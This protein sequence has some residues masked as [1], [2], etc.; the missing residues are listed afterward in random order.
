[1]LLGEPGWISVPE[2]VRVSGA[3][4]EACRADVRLMVEILD[5]VP[6]EPLPSGLEPGQRWVLP[7]RQIEPREQTAYELAA[8][9]FD[10]DAVAAEI[11]TTSAA[12]A[13]VAAKRHAVRVRLPWPPAKG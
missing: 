8:E 5:L 3:A 10:W 9:G 2:L 13:R 12:R 7:G 1:M 11:G 6:A 4:R